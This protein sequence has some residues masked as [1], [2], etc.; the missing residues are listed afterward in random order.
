MQKGQDQANFVKVYIRVIIHTGRKRTP[1]IAPK[2]AD[3]YT[4]LGK[5]TQRR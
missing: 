3:V 2:W 4:E 5:N 1:D